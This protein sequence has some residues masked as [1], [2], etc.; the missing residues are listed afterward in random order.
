VALC[1]VVL[2]CSAEAVTRDD[3]QAPQRA[4]DGRAARA[5]ALFEAGRQREGVQMATRA[6]VERLAYYGVERPEPARSFVQLGDMRRA[7]G[8]LG[9]AEQSYRRAIELAWPHRDTHRTLASHAVERLAALYE[10][11]GRRDRA[12]ALRKRTEAW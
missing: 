8:Q 1:A 12:R 3:L 11:M 9:W 10:H 5:Q 6:L 4:G 2:S 7:L